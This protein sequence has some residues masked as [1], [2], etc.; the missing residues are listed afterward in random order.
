MHRFWKSGI[1]EDVD[2]F[3]H[4]SKG[5][6]LDRESYDSTIILIAQHTRQY[7]DISYSVFYKS[8]ATVTVCFWNVDDK[9]EY[10]DI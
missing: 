9:R 7:L 10:W 6:K 2:D 1:L 4:H 3:K 8:N 5:N